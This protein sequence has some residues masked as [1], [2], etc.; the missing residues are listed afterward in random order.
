MLPNFIIGGVAAG[1]TSF[2]A[3]AISQH[4]EVYLPKKM[5]PEPHYFYKSWEYAK[6]LSYYEKKYFDNIKHE[7]AIGEKS[8]SYLFGGL[9]TARRIKKALP[10]IKLIFALRNPIERTYATYRYTVMQGLEELSFEEALENENT[11]IKKQDGIWK[12]IQ[13]YNYTGRGFYAKQL[14]EYFKV[15]NKEQILILKSEDIYKN[16]YENFQK[17]FA[18]LNINQH[19]SLK[20]PP[21]FTNLSVKDPKLQKYFRNFFGK[22][23]D[24]II[25]S[26]R[27]ENNPLIYAD[28]NTEKLKI[29]ELRQNLVHKKLPMS[30][31]AR[32]YLLEIFHQDMSELLQYIDFDI[33]D[34]R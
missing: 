5:R 1:G 29:I 2:L 17:I 21:H 28:N 6:G 14:K 3:S 9:V 12:E 24:L 20:L 31:Y 22:K 26:I 16:P 19:I 25:E 10:N 11:R 4:P 30:E 8:A 18:F 15:F 7:K 13:P 32:K 23:F 27:K 34:W 33:S